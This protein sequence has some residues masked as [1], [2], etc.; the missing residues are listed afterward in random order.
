MVW[1][2][3]SL[4]TRALS[5]FAFTLFDLDNTGYLDMPEIR[6]LVAEVY[7]DLFESNRRILKLVQSVDRNKD[8]RLSA[9]ASASASASAVFVLLRLTLKFLFSLSPVCL[10]FTSVEFREMNRQY[11]VILFPGFRMQQELRRKVLGEA[12]WQQQLKERM[13]RGVAMTTSIWD[14]LD[15]MDVGNRR[16]EQTAEIEALKAQR[17]VPGQANLPDAAKRR[18]Q[19]AAKK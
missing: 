6:N 10:S 3:C 5:D 9:G 16:S 18:K 8:G 1:N 7:G 11:P 4:D 15:K 13:R 17:W 12:F 2:F 19:A 14:V